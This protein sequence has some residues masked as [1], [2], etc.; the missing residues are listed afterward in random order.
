M[1]DWAVLAQTYS[2]WALSEIQAFSPRERHNW[3]EIARE[4]GKIVRK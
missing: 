4:S 3:L 2:G 1:S